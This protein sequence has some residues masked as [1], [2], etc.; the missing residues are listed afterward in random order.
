MFCLCIELDIEIWIVLLTSCVQYL[1][2]QP[3]LTS[4]VIL[5]PPPQ[6]QVYKSAI[7]LSTLSSIKPSLSCSTFTIA[8]LVRPTL[9]LAALRIA[10]YANVLL[11]DTVFDIRIIEAPLR[12]VMAMTDSNVRKGSLLAKRKYISASLVLKALEDGRSSAKEGGLNFD[13]DDQC[14]YELLFVIFE[15]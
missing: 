2:R 15:L 13:D 5:L 12:A 14:S 6:P 7:W 4:C 8:L 1:L 9:H 3:I 10:S 11:N